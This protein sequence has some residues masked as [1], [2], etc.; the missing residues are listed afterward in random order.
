M[1]LGLR[2]DDSKKILYELQSV[3]FKSFWFILMVQ[4]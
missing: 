3:C 1:S 2:L 4:T